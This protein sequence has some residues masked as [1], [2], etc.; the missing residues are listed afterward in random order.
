MDGV[1]AVRTIYMCKTCG[2]EA[3]SSPVMRIPENTRYGVSSHELRDLFRTEWQRSDASPVVAEFCM[4][5]DIDKN[6]YNKIMERHPEWAEEQ[7]MRAEPF[8]NIVSENPRM[9]AL[10]KVRELEAKTDRIAEQ[11]REIEELRMTVQ[12]LSTLVHRL[13]QMLHATG[14]K[15]VKE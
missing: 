5:H 11:D 14:K 6:D 9:V 4:G 12:G 13:E 2:A 1:S 8:L 7:R 10:E 15:E 3:Y